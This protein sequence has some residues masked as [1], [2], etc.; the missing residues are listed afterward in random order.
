MLI[1]DTKEIYAGNTAITK[2]YNGTN[3][4]YEKQS[5]PVQL[6]YLQS[7]GTQ[8]IDANLPNYENGF[9]VQ[10][11]WSPMSE[12]NNQYIYGAQGNSSA[13]RMNY[14]SYINSSS[15]YLGCYKAFYIYYVTTLDTSYIV[16][17]STIRYNSQYAT[18]DGKKTQTSN[19]MNFG[20]TTNTPFIFALNDDG[21]PTGYATIKLKYMK[22]YDDSD[23]LLRDFIPVLD[24]N[25]VA[26]LYDKVSEIYFYNQGTG[27]FTYG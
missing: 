11:E 23:N 16:E 2:I 25:G 5:G 8:Y 17:T 3:V 19:N 7:S 14:F 27:T 15:F 6:N 1:D 26:C 21:T 20:K 24:A 10:F 22:F 13:R 4:V 9:K 12:T 18:I